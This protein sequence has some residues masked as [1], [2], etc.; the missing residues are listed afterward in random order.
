MQLLGDLSW[1]PWKDLSGVTGTY[2]VT[3]LG[4]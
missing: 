1:Q 2:A 4:S 3:R